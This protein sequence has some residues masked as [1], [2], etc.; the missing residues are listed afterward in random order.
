MLRR[1]RTFVAGAVVAAAPL[2]TLAM[3]GIA[4][5]ATYTCTWV[6]GGGDSNFSTA[7]NWTGC[8]S[9]APQVADTNDLVFPTDT[10]TDFAPVNDLVGATFNSITFNGTGGSTAF[11]ITGT[12]FTLAGDLTDSSDQFNTIENNITLPGTTTSTVGGSAM[13]T[14]SGTVSG[15]GSIVNASG[16]IYLSSVTL[17]G[18][19]TVN[20]GSLN[21]QATSSADATVSSVTVASGAYFGYDAFGSSGATTYA[22]STPINSAGGTLDFQ[23]FGSGTL[24]LN[25]TGTIT[26]TGNTQV[27]MSN[28]TTVNVQGPLHGPTFTLTK[29][30]GTGVLSIQSSDNTSATPNDPVVNPASNTADDADAPATPDTG[31]ALVKANPGVSLA[32]TLAGTAAILV[33]ARM[34]RKSGFRR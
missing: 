4:H 29:G 22:L 7:A 1:I 16:T 9:A 3:P 33:A 15:S 12:D 26:L 6:G 14:L 17:T 18:A 34:T 28:G 24:T 11:D 27:W 31:F 25:L 8:N 32:I 20:G 5:A 21:M 19:I 10:A 2:A 23:T 30:A 13:L